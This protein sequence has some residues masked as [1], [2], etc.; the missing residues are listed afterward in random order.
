MWRSRE[1]RYDVASAI[2]TGAR[3]YQEDAI[4]SDFLVGAD[5]GFVVVADGMGGHAAGDVA[6][7]IVLTKVFS[8]LKFQYADVDRFEA[9]ATRVLREIAEVANECI[10]A[11]IRSHPETRGMGSTLVVPVILE[12]RLFWISIGDSPLYRLRGGK[13]QQLNAD[14]SMAPQIDLMVATGLMR[15]EVARDHPDRNCLTS[16]LM[17][18]R[19]AKVDCPSEPVELQAGDILLCGSDGMQVLPDA[20][21]ERLLTKYRRKR[22][23]EIAERLLDEIRAARNPHQDNVSFCIIKINDASA[24]PLEERRRRTPAGALQAGLLTRLVTEESAEPP[25]MA[26]PAPLKAASRGR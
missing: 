5:S 14:H 2:D 8:E 9:G 7:K 19:I 1:P 11:H 26:E 20:H 23:S 3:D 18:G 6:S 24:T 22:S 10:G 15:P 21:L 12:N 13:L 4:T 17:G 25:A 16:A